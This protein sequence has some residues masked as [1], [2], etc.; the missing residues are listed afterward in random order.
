MHGVRRKGGNGGARKYH[1]LVGR[2]NSTTTAMALAAVTA[3]VFIVPPSQIESRI[4]TGTKYLKKV[5]DI[6]Q[7]LGATFSPLGIHPSSI[8]G[9]IWGRILGAKNC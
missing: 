7:H 3:I 1:E 2:S 9:G 8:P 5:Y 6:A 4:G